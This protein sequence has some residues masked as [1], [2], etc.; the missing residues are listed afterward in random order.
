MVLPCSKDD[1]SSDD[2]AD[3]KGQVNLHVGEEDE[4]FVPCAL[5]EFASRFCTT[6]TA[7]WVLSTDTYHKS[8]KSMSANKTQFCVAHAYSEKESIYNERRQ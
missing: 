2:G 8:A 3:K 7:R 1:D 6:D 4:P 5:L